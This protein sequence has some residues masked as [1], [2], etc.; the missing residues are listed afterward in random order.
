MGSIST[1][2]VLP[3]HLHA[4][5][6]SA[7]PTT[8]TVRL[9]GIIT[10]VSGDQ[11]T[12]TCGT[13]ATTIILNRYTVPLVHLYTLFVTILL[14]TTSDSD[15]HLQVNAMYEI[16]GKVINLEGGAGTGVRVLSSCEWPKNQRGELPDMKLYEAVVDVTHKCR[17]IFYEGG[18]DENADM[19][20]Y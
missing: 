19:G 20:G 15:S 2:R 17:G 3:S 14:T 11:A 9:L 7:H 1:P 10:T 4:F 13:E 5:A 12:L 6:P 8:N 18:A 16:V